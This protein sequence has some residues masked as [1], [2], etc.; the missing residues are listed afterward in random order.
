MLHIPD[1]LI[2]HSSV[3]RHHLSV[4]GGKHIVPPRVH[5]PM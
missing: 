4:I 1:V 2:V 3:L 5:V